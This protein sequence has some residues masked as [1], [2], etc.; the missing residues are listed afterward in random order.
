MLRNAV[1]AGRPLLA[2]RAFHSSRVTCD[3]V[4]KA[5]QAAA[6]PKA[7]ETLFSKILRKEI[8]SKGVYEDELVYAFRD[9]APQAP[10]HI[11]VIPKKPIPQ[12]SKAEDGDTMILGHLLQT[13]RKIADQE[14]LSKDGFRIVINDG[15][16]GAQSV[17]HLHVH[18]VGGRQLGWPP[19]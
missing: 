3:E 17:Y 9:I 7:T 12:L 6:K 13:A 19:G 4:K 10:T 16:H 14:G 8:P 11:L 2:R 15:K 5:Q 18:L 1:G